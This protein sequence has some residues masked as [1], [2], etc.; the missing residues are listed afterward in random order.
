MNL[1]E[2]LSSLLLRLLP[3]EHFL[4]IRMAYFRLRKK[5]SPLLRF[6]HGTFTTEELI[7]EIDARLDQDWDILMVHSSVNNLA[8]MYQGS[9]LELVKG[10]IDYCGPERTLV[11]PAFNLG[12]GDEGARETLRKNPRFDLRRT[13]SHMGLAT[14]LFRRHKG[15]VQSKHPAYRIAA[16][17]PHAI[18]LTKGHE[19]A[20]SGMG[21]NTPFDFMAKQRAQILGIGKSFQVMTQAHHVETLVGE[22]WP[23][24]TTSLPNLKVVVVDRDE[25]LEM[26]IGGT[27]QQWTFNIWKLRELLPADRLRE[28]RFHNCPMFA[29]RADVVTD[30]LVSAARRGFTLYDP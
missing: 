16:L 20:P 26:E 5:A 14:E 7:E 21:E 15:V 2:S 24:P 19:L 11:M 22:E 27:Q 29:A 17:G 1:T 25:E 6:I 3:R 23:A 12:D 4:K 9:A 10:L 28:W 13:P 8:P 30:T 18:D